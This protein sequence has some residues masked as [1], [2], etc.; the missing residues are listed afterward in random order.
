MA[1]LCLEMQWNEK[2]LKE[3]SVIFIDELVRAINHRNKRY[4]KQ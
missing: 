4:G 1:E 3:N 2:Q